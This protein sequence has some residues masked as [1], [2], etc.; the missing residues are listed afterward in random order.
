MPR[1]FFHVYDDQSLLDDEGTELADIY[2]AQG[3]AIRMSGE[4]IRDLRGQ[5]W[6]SGEWRLE[7]TDAR[8]T[9][10]FIVRFSAE[11]HVPN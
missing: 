3:Q 4:I 7:V 10:L 1:F 5:F 2:V 6:N 9:T 11:E 8:G